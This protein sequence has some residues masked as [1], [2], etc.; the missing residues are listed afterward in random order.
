MLS[1]TPA[2][3]EALVNSYVHGAQQTW[4][5]APAVATGPT[6]DLVIAFI[7]EGAGDAN[8]IFARRLPK[9]GS[10]G[11]QFRVNTTTSGDQMSPGVAVADNGD[12]VIVWSG[13]GTGDRA[14]VFA[15][16]FGADG[17]SKSGEILVNETVVGSQVHPVVAVTASGGF[18][19][20]W[21]G[22][23][24]GDADGVFLRRFQ[25]DGTPSGGE[26]RL[27]SH[28]AGTQDFAALDADGSG[29]LVA[30]WS[31]LG[32][33]SSGWGVFAQRLA[34][35]GS[36]VGPE[37]QLSNTTTLD[38]IHAQ[39][40]VAADGR[41][42]AAWTSVGQDGDGGGIFARRFSA[43]S[44]PLADEFRVNKTTALSQQDA[45]LS[46][47]DDGQLSVVW[48]SAAGD[49]N[50]WDVFLQEF[51]A[52]GKRD[53]GETRVNTTLSGNQQFAGVAAADNGALAVAWSGMG[54]GDRDGVFVRRFN[55]QTDNTP[56]AIAAHL[57]KDTAPSGTNSDR[58]TF[59]P[60]IAGTVTDRGKIASLQAGVDGRALGNVT[61][62][63]QGAFRIER[64]DLNHLAGGKLADG[65]HTVRLEARDEAGNK[66]APF[67]LTF[68]LD[69]TPPATLAIP[70]LLPASDSG[71]SDS[72]NITRDTT[73]TIRVQA[74]TGTL[75]RLFVDGQQSGEKTAASPVDFTTA[76]LAAGVHRF[77]AAAV[78]A[79]GNVSER[80]SAL[81]VRIDTAGPTLPRFD[82]DPASDT[83]P[84]GNHL[85]RNASVTLAGQTSRNTSVRLLQ[86]GA[87]TT[88][89]ADGKFHFSS[90]LLPLGTKHF[91]V[92]ATD[93]EGD[94]SD[95][96][97][98]ITRIIRPLVVTP[99][100]NQRVL[101]DAADLTLD[102]AGNFLGENVTLSVRQNT[103][104]NLVQ[105]TLTGKTLKLHFFANRNG[106]SD[107]TIRATD[108][109]N[110]FSEDTFRVNVVSVND[111]PTV[112]VPTS[113]IL[114]QQNAPDRIVNLN[115]AFGDV[116]N[117]GT[118]LRF[119][120]SLG[121]FGLE[122]YDDATPLTAANF[123]H[124]VNRPAAQGGNYAGS[125]IH[126]SASISSQSNQ[127]LPVD[128]IQGGGFRFPGFGQVKPDAP[129]NNEFLISNTPGTIAMAKTSNPNSATSQW[130]VNVTNNSTGLDNP[131]NSGGFTVFGRVIG[132]GM[133]TVNA[134]AA[135]QRFNLSSLGGALGQIPLRNYTLTNPITPPTANNVVLVTG[136]SE[137]E[138][139]TGAKGGDRQLTLSIVNN[140]NAALVTPTLGADRRLQ[141]HFAAG[142]S[143]VAQIDVRAIDAGGL[144]VTSSI[145]VL[146]Q[147]PSPLRLA[148]ESDAPPALTAAQLE[149]LPAA[150]A[151]AGMQS[152]IAG[153]A[154]RW[155]AAGLDSSLASSLAGM[156]VHVAD[157]PG[158]YLGYAADGA[159][160][161][162]A[163][164][165]GRGWFVDPTPADNAEFSADDD[166]MALA[167]S[168]AAGRV[169]LLS[170][171][172]HEMGHSLG[173]EH[174]ENANG[175]A[176]IMADQIQP[177][178]RRL[179]S[180]RDVDQVFSQDEDWLR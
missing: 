112:V 24:K 174:A 140:S 165:A 155:A 101:E 4:P 96:S 20:A 159:L 19:V 11:D 78:D 62:D 63:P 133:D 29:R 154:A 167:G 123:M 37:F 163:D 58:L 3:S 76:T 22:N 142:K 118:L 49:S 41:F 98:D 81:S 64:A 129:V 48:S 157:L 130:F 32:Q 79:A 116:D 147:A 136:V 89:D 72:D 8:G 43:D 91:T 39:V 107:L 10:G 26:T 7:G 143:G 180:H 31:S 168:Q 35:D 66:S 80:S 23:G 92:R 93:N 56:P 126:R 83:A 156:N 18:A 45:Q 119:D 6:G 105:A 90:V 2:G 30:V 171:L 137:D 69:T 54:D 60:T 17:K 135:L 111:A 84:A 9:N 138:S 75:V 131:V 145:T 108:S 148:G 1:A 117:V 153:A 127:A 15:R 67:Q 68:T 85:T 12:F 95:F 170:V 13:Q 160:W 113:P 169:D 110:S 122:M 33:D 27:N 47:A 166:G 46:L 28:T 99:I 25:Q 59:D 172:A 97:R 146:V 73:P 44:T 38:Q 109:D 14:G 120:T 121:Q 128:I 51:D 52:G 55:S 87:T 104:P 65:Q 40:S 125:I 149:T 57:A 61:V 144:S 124:Y 103:E 34:A 74:P 161:I 179:P 16:Q 100:A 164:A 106:H 70:D 94:Q 114:V 115:G 50:G 158:S 173:L 102:L 21:S 175:L 134:I 42:A 177:S 141:L 88:S 132:N 86:T 71:T 82:L 139:L 150:A 152:A 151:P 176:D 36:R 178:V 162:D 5:T 77:A 53:G